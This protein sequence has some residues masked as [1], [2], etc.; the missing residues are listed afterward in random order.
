MG[1]KSIVRSLLRQKLLPAEVHQKADELFKVCIARYFNTAPMVGLYCALPDEVRLTWEGPCFV[2]VGMEC[3]LWSEDQSPGQYGVM[4]PN[5]GIC[6][7]PAGSVVAVPGLAFCSDGKRL[8]RGQGYYDRFL[9]QHSNLVR[10]GIAY[11]IDVY[12]WPSETHDVIMD[13]LIDVQS[14]KIFFFEDRLKERGLLL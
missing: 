14:E 1:K 11:G 9:A 13:A 2:P 7:V 8:G 12:D 5:T 4:V 6:Q 3:R 10:L